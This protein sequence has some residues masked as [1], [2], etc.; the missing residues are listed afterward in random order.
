[1]SINKYIIAV[2]LGLHIIYWVWLLLHNYTFVAKCWRPV[3]YHIIAR[4]L[5]RLDKPWIRKHKKKQDA[6]IRYGLGFAV[7]SLS[8]IMLHHSMSADVSWLCRANTTILVSLSMPHRHKWDVWK[9]WY[10]LSHDDNSFQKISILDE[11]LKAKVSL[12]F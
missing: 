11:C 5:Q 8:P 9:A 3:F 1:M 6:S 12:K 2:V 7:R 10:A 4:W